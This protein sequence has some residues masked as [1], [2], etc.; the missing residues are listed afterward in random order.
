MLLNNKEITFCADVQ[1][2]RAAQEP[3]CRLGTIRILLDP[4]YKTRSILYFRSKTK[5]SPHPAFVEWSSKF[6][7]TARPE[8]AR[9]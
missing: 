5:D 7:I 9:F 4:L 3:Q 6:E 2:I 8:L 1:L